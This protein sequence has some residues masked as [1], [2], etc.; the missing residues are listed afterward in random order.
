[1]R[2]LCDLFL[3]FV[4]VTNTNQNPLNSAQTWIIFVLVHAEDAEVIALSPK[5]LLATNMFIW[6]MSCHRLSVLFRNIGGSNCLKIVTLAWLGLPD[7]Y[8]R[9]FW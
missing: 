5:T 8:P 1:M 7:A 9:C 6:E 4:F 2:E 3:I